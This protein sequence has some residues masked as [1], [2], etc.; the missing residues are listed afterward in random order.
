MRIFNRARNLVGQSYT[1]LKV[2][3]PIFNFSSQVSRLA[4]PDPEIKPVIF[5]NASTRLVGVSL[6]AAFSLLTA[7]ALRLQDVPVIY[8]VCQAGMTRCVL[9]T[10]RNDF[11][12]APPCQECVAQSRWLFSGA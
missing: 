4:R 12:K 10:Y 6:N 2:N 5:F 8:F 11:S 1:R 3:L 9:G 7:W